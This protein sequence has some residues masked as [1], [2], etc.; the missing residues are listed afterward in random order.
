[1]KREPEKE[2]PGGRRISGSIPPKKFKV[3][4]GDLH[5]PS[6][7]ACKQA[8]RIIRAMGP[9]PSEGDQRDLHEVLDE[10]HPDDEGMERIRDLVVHS[11]A[12]IPQAVQAGAIVNAEGLRDFLVRW[13]K[14]HD[15]I[16]QRELEE[17][18]RREAEERSERLAKSATRAREEQEYRRRNL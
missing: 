17:R 1:M 3:P 12:G 8:L 10:W 2:A 18:A 9:I 11:S 7:E 14:E 15:T 6:L 5:G 13:R 4:P 16:Y